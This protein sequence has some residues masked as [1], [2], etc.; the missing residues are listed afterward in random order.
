M[1]HFDTLLL[2][3]YFGASMLVIAG[4]GVVW[5]DEAGP[6]EQ[7]LPFSHRFHVGQAELECTQCHQLADKGPQATVPPMSVCAECHAGMATENPEI[8]KLQ[9]HLEN[10]IPVAWNRVHDLPWHA[11]FTHKRHIRAGIECTTCH[12][13]VQ[14]MERV[15]QVLPLTMGWCVS[16]HRD[17]DAP[18]D[19]LTCHK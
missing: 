4:F 10:D 12:G 9:E 13:E 14:A 18:T 3:G 15:R 1:R 19:C 6:V 8:K 11:V 5:E 16:C 2:A 7:P 17:N